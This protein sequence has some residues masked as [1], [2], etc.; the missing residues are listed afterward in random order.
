MEGLAYSLQGACKG[1]AQGLQWLLCVCLRGTFSVL[2]PMQS[3]LVVGANR[4]KNLPLPDSGRGRLLLAIWTEPQPSCVAA[5]N[6]RSP[7]PPV[8]LRAA[9]GAPTLLCRC[10]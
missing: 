10:W 1:L 3:E 6:G 7:Y 5:G 2:T 9:D 8:S 4:K